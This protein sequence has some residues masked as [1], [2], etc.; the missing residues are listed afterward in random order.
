MHRPLRLLALAAGAAVVAGLVLPGQASAGGPTSVLIVSP[1]T[2]ETASLYYDD[3]E[4]ALLHDLLDPI[5]TLVEKDHPAS[6]GPGT[7]HINVTWLIHDVVA[8]R[9]HRIDLD[10]TG[11]PL[12]NTNGSMSASEPFDLGEPGVWHRASNPAALNGLLERLG[13]L[14]AK[15]GTMQP[16]SATVAPPAPAGTDA[17]AGDG[18]WWA[19]PALAGGL[20]IGL[21]GRPHAAAFLRR[22]RERDRGPVHQ[23]IDL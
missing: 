22:W 6:V 20:A 12:I 4:Y 8:W 23:L 2:G 10:A 18:L 17:S 1:T 21:V 11:G 9:V 3:P 19:L 16:A 5:P 14:N 7:R 15:S 13:V